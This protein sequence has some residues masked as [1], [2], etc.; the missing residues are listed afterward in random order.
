MRNNSSNVPISVIIPVYNGEKYIEGCLAS[1]CEQSMTELEII[2]VDDGSTD[3]TVEI[4]RRV[5]SMDSRVTV[6]SHG[7]NKGLFAARIT[8]V[9]ASCG[10]YIAFVD[11]DDAVSFDWFRL[12][13]KTA[14]EEGNDITIGQFYCDFG[15]DRFT[16]FNLNPLRQKIKLEGDE[17]FSAFIG[18]EGSCYSW[19]LVWNKL[20]TRSIWMDAMADLE[21]FSKE[22]PRFVMCEDIAFSGTLW[23]RAKKVSNVQNGAVYYY[24]RANEN[25]STAGSF[26]RSKTLNNIKNVTGA[27][28]LMEEQMKKMGFYEKN[29]AHFYAWKLYY[30]RMY[31]DI[32]QKDSASNKKNDAHIIYEAFQIEDADD[33]TDYK[34]SYHYFY[35]AETNVNTTLHEKMEETKRRICS[36]D[37]KVVSFDVFDTLILRPFWTPTDL[38]LLMNDAFHRECTVSSYVDFSE[39]RV[40]AERD[41]RARI[42]K[43]HPQYE[44]ITL[45]EIYDQLEKD[46]CLDRMALEKLKALEQELELRFC[47]ERKMGR[48][49]FELARSQGKQVIICSDMYLPRQT[50]E[51]ILKKNGYEYDH[52]YLSSELRVSK[53][54]QALFKHVQKELA[55]EPSACFHIGDNVGSDVQAP[56]KCGWDASH[57]AKVTDLFCNRIEGCCGGDA[58]AKIWGRMG[59]VQDTQNGEASFLGERCAMAL[60]A[61]KLCDDPYLTVAAESDFNADP[62]RLGY[63]ALGHYLYAVTDWVVGQVKE[64]KSSCVHFVA[65]DGYL[66][67]LAYEHFKKYDVTLPRSNYLYVSR[68][69]MALADVYSGCDLYSFAKKFNY[70]TLSPYK[71]EKMLLPYYRDG[72]GSIQEDMN[73]SNAAFRRTFCGPSA[74]YQASNLI[75]EKLDYEKLKAQ[76]S[77]LYAYFSK[78]YQPNDILFDIGYSGRVEAAMTR[79]LGYPVNSLYLH[80]MTDSLQNRE[81]IYG[82]QNECFYDHKPAVT[83]VIREHV[84]MK[85]APSTIGFEKVDGE[86]QPVFEAY[87][88][89]VGNEIVMRT[90]QGA[91]VEFVHDML[92]VF[93]GYRSALSYQKDDMAYPFEYYLHYSKDLD[94]RIFACVMFEDDIGVGKDVSALSCWNRDIYDFNL[95]RFSGSGSLDA[96]D[97]CEQ[98]AKLR[99]TFMPYARWKKAICYLLLEPRGF[100]QRVKRKLFKK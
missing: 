99:S 12:L 19:H 38:F 64:K 1:I 60:A 8:G 82:F 59:Q 50:V 6:I 17:V 65:R 55:V 48:Q 28:D 32:L 24:N 75:A 5:A 72:V 34:K 4:A 78:I 23:T 39:I 70:Q 66:P 52:L 46:Y 61:N 36:P 79:L 43:E 89:T 11:A 41:C 27:F 22:H 40:Q 97:A 87:K 13:Y 83:G 33:V 74:F 10:N 85:P 91:A 14:T 9:Q 54:S 47:V 88:T 58:Y 31:Y 45:D 30:A 90:L 92:S 67:M 68:K 57:F 76:K 3:T 42:R 25:Q 95:E 69:A 77:D 18:Q 100:M 21:Q 86:L 71:Y 16:F 94:R 84:F 56:K 29:K 20:Y 2:V 96:F 49:L 62:Y 26:E 80:A 15:N 7:E 93:E 44:E 63:F 81:R 51:A 73:V 37:I 35:S 53:G 98:D